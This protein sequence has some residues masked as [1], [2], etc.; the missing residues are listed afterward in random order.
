MK[1][2]LNAIDAHV[3]CR[4]KPGA[5][6]GQKPGDT[7]RC[8]EKRCHSRQPTRLLKWSMKP[9]CT[10]GGP[11]PGSEGKPKSVITNITAAAAERHP[12]TQCHPSRDAAAFHQ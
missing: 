11:C 2:R 3:I 5:H 9:R 1:R 12:N 10:R 4:L 6:V 7:A 8:K